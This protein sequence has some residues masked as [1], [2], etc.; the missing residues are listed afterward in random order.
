MTLHYCWH[1]CLLPTITH[2]EGDTRFKFRQGY[3][4]YLVGIIGQF[5]GVFANLLKVIVSLVM[6][7]HLSLH[8][9]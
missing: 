3:Q 1:K 5:L 6:S 2:V 7:V 9:H 4:Q 8:P